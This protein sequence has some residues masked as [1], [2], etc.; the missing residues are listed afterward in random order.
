MIP[1]SNVLFDEGTIVGDV[2]FENPLAEEYLGSDPSALRPDTSEVAS[3]FS[4]PYT[5]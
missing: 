1:A 2:W 5:P 3:V 4:T